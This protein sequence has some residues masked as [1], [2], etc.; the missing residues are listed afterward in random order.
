MVVNT[1]LGVI[2]VCLFKNE[3][4]NISTEAYQGA[5]YSQRMTSSPHIRKIITERNGHPLPRTLFSEGISSL[6]KPVNPARAA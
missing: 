2:Q 6:G 4:A 1:R 3:R 5:K